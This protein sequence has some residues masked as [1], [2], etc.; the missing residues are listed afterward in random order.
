[1]AQSKPLTSL[2]RCQRN[3]GT[4]G[5]ATATAMAVAGSAEVSKAMIATA[6]APASNQLLRLG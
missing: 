3:T 4:T 1:V 6:A 5:P 2:Q